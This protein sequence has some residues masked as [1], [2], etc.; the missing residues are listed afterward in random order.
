MTLSRARSPQWIPWERGRAKQ[1]IG[2]LLPCP[3]FMHRSGTQIVRWYS[4]YCFSQRAYMGHV[5]AFFHWLILTYIKW[6]L[7]LRVNLV[8]ERQCC[9][10]FCNGS[11]QKNETDESAFEKILCT[12]FRDHWHVPLIRGE[13]HHH[14]SPS[15]LFIRG[16]NLD[17]SAESKARLWK[18]WWKTSGNVE[19]GCQPCA[20]F[21]ASPWQQW[22]SK[23]L[24]RKN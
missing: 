2:F 16:L 10:I 6:N 20:A 4:T 14:S 3:S 18:D 7:I 11:F 17:H 21:R 23:S 9:T 13:C 5:L 1:S 8:P 19:I 22:H 24:P 12:S 15:S